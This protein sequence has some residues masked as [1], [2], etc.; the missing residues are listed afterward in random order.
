MK[1]EFIHLNPNDIFK[2]FFE[3]YEPNK[4]YFEINKEEK[5][6]GFYG[7]KRVGEKSGEISVYF[8]EGDRR[9]IT[10]RVAF[11]CLFFPFS[12]G[13]EKVLISTKLK[14]IERFLRKMQK[15]GIKYLL[16]NN[17]FHWFEI[18]S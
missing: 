17:D 10:K 1:V 2:H 11:E 5:P 4:E 8:N 7:I 12:L 9:E 16:K 14:K 3:F 6:I 13:F 15:F 18:T